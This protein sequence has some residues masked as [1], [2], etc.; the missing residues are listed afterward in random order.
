MSRTLP[1]LVLLGLVA[2][3]GCESFALPPNNPNLVLNYAP[4]SSHVFPSLNPGDI[5][6]LSVQVTTS[7]GKPVKGV[8]VIWDDLFSPVRAQPQRSLS[9]SS[10]QVTAAWTLPLLPNGTF[11]QEQSIRAY[12]PGADNSPLTFTALVVRCTRCAQ[13]VAGD[14]GVDPQQP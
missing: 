10:G 4:G 5:V 14:G 8:E 6:T 9:D 13:P 1:A 3:G 7:G 2:V 11:S 12:L